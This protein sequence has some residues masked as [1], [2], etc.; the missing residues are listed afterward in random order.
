MSRRRIGSR[1]EAA[2]RR[3]MADD[4]WRKAPPRRPGQAGISATFR[5]ALWSEMLDPGLRRVTIRDVRQI[6][7][8]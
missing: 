5:S 7:G 2:D 8:L 3:R 6:R 4:G 1:Q